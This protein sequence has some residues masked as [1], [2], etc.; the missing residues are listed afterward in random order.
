MIGLPKPLQTLLIARL[1]FNH[2]VNIISL[3]T[4]A[5]ISV[6]HARHEIFCSDIYGNTLNIHV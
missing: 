3:E 4:Y 6:N 2:S 5:F 1:N